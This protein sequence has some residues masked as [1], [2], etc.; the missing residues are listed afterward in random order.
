MGVC[1]RE[2]ISAARWLFVIVVSLF[3][4]GLAQSA[5]AQGGTVN[6]GPDRTIPDSNGVAGETVTLTVAGVTGNISFFEWRLGSTVLGT[7]RSISASLPD[8]ANVVTLSGWVGFPEGPPTATDTVTITVST[9]VCSITS[10][11]VVSRG[12][13]DPA[14]GHIVVTNG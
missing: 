9:T 14:R 13:H 3:G 11:R 8:G 5:F 10:S 7:G 12:P 6:A 1:A 2:M 4:A